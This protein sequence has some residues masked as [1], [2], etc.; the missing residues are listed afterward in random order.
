MMN[1]RNIADSKRVNRILSAL[2]QNGV[3]TPEAAGRIAREYLAGKNDE[4]KSIVE[5]KETPLALM[6]F[7]IELKNY[8]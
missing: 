5:S 2:A 3:I 1:L 6:P 7:I 4:L 8:V